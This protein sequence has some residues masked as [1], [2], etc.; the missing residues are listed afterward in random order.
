MM[1]RIYDTNDPARSLNSKAS[2]PLEASCRHIILLGRSNEDRLLA[3]YVMH[4]SS[5][6]ELPNTLTAFD[7]EPEVVVGKSLERG[8]EL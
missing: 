4:A 1:L 7:C 5:I 8:W 6:I 3:K 2:S